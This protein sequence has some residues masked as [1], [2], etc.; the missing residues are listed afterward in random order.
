MRLL[1]RIAAAALVG[2]GGS[3]VILQTI[4]EPDYQLIDLQK[5]AVL[6]AIVAIFTDRL[7]AAF[8][9]NIFGPRE[10]GLSRHKI[11]IIRRHSNPEWSKPRS[12]EL[13]TLAKEGE[14]LEVIA[15]QIGVSPNSAR[16]KMVNLGIYNDYQLARVERLETDLDKAKA[17]F[18]TTKKRSARAVSPNKSTRGFSIED[19][20]DKKLKHSLKSLEQLIG[21]QRLKDEVA[22]LIALSRVQSSRADHGLPISPPTFHLVFSG[23]PGTGKTT[24]AR[25]L[26]EV[27]KSL[28]LLKAGH[29]VEVSRADLVGEYVGHTAPKV[30]AIVEKALDGV[31]FIDE[32]YSL[33]SSGHGIPDYG[34]EAVDALLKLM[35]DNRHRL[36]VIVAGYPDLMQDF[37]RSNPGLESRFKTTLHFDDYEIPE[38]LQI[39]LSLCNRHKLRL[40]AET[41]G[42]AR[43]AFRTLRM[44]KEGRFANGREVRNLF[45]R[46]LTQQALRLGNDLTKDTLSTLAPTDISEATTLLLNSPIDSTTR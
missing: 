33:T 8:L 19:I 40:D 46:V 15:N 28:G 36:V 23:N 6:L 17:A 24:V 2:V 1:L 10:K 30:T 26:G 38:L 37:L 4:S 34:P 11:E 31:L 27:Y 43:N 35:E 3:V 18:V 29:C 16:A 20:D 13:E 42:A 9:E 21:L 25:I 12:D 45:E 41:Q 5:Q 22:S 32:A 39:F 7:L 14:H 44:E